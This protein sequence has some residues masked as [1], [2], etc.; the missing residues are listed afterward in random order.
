MCVISDFIP[1]TTETSYLRCFHMWG[2][3]M[4]GF[5]IVLYFR[6]L[7]EHHHWD[8]PNVC[9]SFPFMTCGLPW[10]FSVGAALSMNTCS[11]CFLVRPPYLTRPLYFS[12]SLLLYMFVQWIPKS[13]GR[14]FNWLIEFCY[15]FMQQSQ[16]PLRDCPCLLYSLVHCGDFGTDNMLLARLDVCYLLLFLQRQLF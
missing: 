10:P 13:L 15:S 6:G 5:H 4:V 11:I 2:V 9:L 14:Q 7:N 16:L 3:P 1:N 8:T 12:F